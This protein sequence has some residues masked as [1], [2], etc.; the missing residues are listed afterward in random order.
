M[1]KS[2]NPNASKSLAKVVNW[3]MSSKRWAEDAKT[4]TKTKSFKPTNSNTINTFIENEEANNKYVTVK[5]ESAKSSKTSISVP[6]TKTSKISPEPKNENTKPSSY[7]KSSIFK[8]TPNKNIAKEPAPS[9]TP[10]SGKKIDEVKNTK[11]KQ[12]SNDVKITKEDEK[13][14]KEKSLKTNKTL[15]QITNTMGLKKAD[16]F[17]V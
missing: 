11:E 16:V 2:T 14:P 7:V 4:N 10:V 17:E 3:L 8:T 6:E 13:V 1:E 15:S 12:S 9:E 5:I